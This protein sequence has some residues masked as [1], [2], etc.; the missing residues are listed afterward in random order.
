MAKILETG[1]AGLSWDDLEQWA[2]AKIL[3]RGKS[4]R[5]SVQD[6][7]ITEDHHLVATVNGSEPYITHVWLEGGEPACE[8]S[9][10]YLYNCKHA[11]AV[12]LAY[13]DSIRS[14]TPV[15]LIQPDEL[16]ARLSIYGMAED[17]DDGP[18]ID[19]E[20]ARALLKK[21]TKAQLIEWAIEIF[22]DDASF[23][24]TLPGTEQPAK[25]PPD[26]II[27]E[28]RQQIRKT[29]SDR[30]WRNYWNNR[31][32]TPDYSPIKTQLEKLL[33]GGHTEVVLELGEELLTLGNKQVEE[34]NDEG[35]TA[36]ELFGCL[37]LVMKALTK[38]QRPSAEKMIWY[39]D[40][41]LHG[42]FVLFDGLAP[43]IDNE[44]M[45]RTDW[46]QVAEEFSHR[47]AQCPK[48]RNTQGWS[49]NRY[50][51]E[52][53]LGYV[54]EALSQ[55]GEG[56]RATELM[57]AE[58]PY[59]ANY[60]EL[61]DRLSANKDHDNAEQWAY[62]GFNE[63][64]RTS[65][66]IAWR[67]LDRLRD[68]AGKRKDWPRVAALRVDAFLQ[69]TD[70]DNY[71]SAQKSCKEA[72]S[73]SQVRDKLLVF[74]ETGQSPLAADDWPLPDTTLEFPATKSRRNKPDY[75]VLI[76]VALYEKRN[77]DA[78]HWFR[79]MSRRSSH[80]EAIA[81]AVKKTHPDVSLKIWRSKAEALIARVKPDAYREA[82][83]YLKSIKSL[84]RSLK[85][86]DDYQLY[87]ARLRNRHKAK[88]LLMRE[89]DALDSKKGGRILA[90]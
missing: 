49:S 84:M 69:Q 15:P 35:E 24:D 86:N 55:A 25:A 4:Y 61:V 8:C 71:K 41:L 63:T 78:L 1:F 73:W 28:L 80:A 72:K 38:S 7:A 65:P 16:E 31:G 27:A 60:V 34:S 9:C 37:D 58:L 56:P 19:P 76:E 66:G 47:L 51:R 11:V 54:V 23:F 45:T 20:Q 85:R 36:T 88:R 3:A 6:L 81:Q 50:H 79:Q 32:Y 13:L 22:A 5:R 40:K 12:I 18:G 30:G 62:K 52:R 43:P 26:K 87:I 33:R 77:E 68:I 90:D 82:M 46:R 29:T 64:I 70:L 83:S 10:P 2:G 42:D 74:L 75:D 21:F 57:I 44:V 53:V 48:P 14:K 17:G 39:W 59:C 67:L 89:L